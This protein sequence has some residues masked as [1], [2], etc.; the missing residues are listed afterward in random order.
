MKTKV[1]MIRNV[2]QG[3]C[4]LSDIE[5]YELAEKDGGGTDGAVPTEEWMRQMEADDGGF[6]FEEGAAAA[7]PVGLSDEQ[8]ARMER[9]K[10]TALKKAAGRKANASG[11][12]NEDE[13]ALEWEMEAAAGGGG[14]GGGG[15]GFDDFDEEA[16]ADM[17]FDDDFFGSAAPPRAAAPAP[18]AAPAV[19]REEEEAAARAEA[20]MEAEMELQAEM[21]MGEG[22]NDSQPPNDFTYREPA[23]ASAD[24]QPPNDFTYREPACD[25]GESQLSS[26]PPEPPEALED[27]LTYREPALPL[28][29]EE[30]AAT[31]EA[32]ESA[33]RAASQAAAE[34]LEAGLS[35]DEF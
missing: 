28:S 8:R 18:R 6:H 35:D 10:Q 25:V 2:Q 32:A 3:E 12:V 23:A 13:I 7:E 16:E 21:A 19:S 24:S 33:A 14:G 5:D 1:E 22:V 11:G 26:Q 4:S 9:N 20:E 15:E 17:G 27:D 29:A 31:A 30:E 34:A